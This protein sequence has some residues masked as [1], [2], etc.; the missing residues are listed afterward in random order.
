MH[1]Y[2]V[3]VAGGAAIEIRRQRRLGEQTKGVGPPLG[4]RHFLRQTLSLRHALTLTEQ[5]IG[6]GLE[7]AMDD[8]AHLG[9]EAA[10]NDHHPVLVDPGREVAMEMSRL[11]L[12][13]AA[14]RS[15]RRHA[16]AKRSM[17]AAVP[18]WAKSS[19]AAS[20]SGVAMRVSA[21]TLA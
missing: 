19:S 17:W 11:G 13:R 6:G 1:H 8:G 21:L 20:F 9:R 2:L 18:A 3:A 7:R 14:T 10:A 5:P 4:R 15:T 16:P 12:R